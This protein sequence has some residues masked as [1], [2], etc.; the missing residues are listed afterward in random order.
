MPR[1][2]I[3]AWR[4]PVSMTYSAIDGTSVPSRA[5]EKALMNAACKCACSGSNDKRDGDF[6]EV[7][8]LRWYLQ[9]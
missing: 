8:H 6:A 4:L 9:G 3:T 5:L 1:H 7:Q 2:M